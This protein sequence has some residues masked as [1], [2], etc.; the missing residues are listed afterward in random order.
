MIKLKFIPPYFPVLL[1]PVYWLYFLC[2]YLV[3][4]PF[5]LLCLLFSPWNHKKS[6]TAIYM[7]KTSNNK[8]NLN[9]EGSKGGEEDES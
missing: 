6:L 1:L 3:Y 4:L 5:Y 9:V 7:K 8:R 2:F